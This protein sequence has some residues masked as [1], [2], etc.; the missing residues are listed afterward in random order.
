MEGGRHFR[1]EGVSLCNFYVRATFLLLKNFELLYHELC[2][3]IADVANAVLCSLATSIDIPSQVSMTQ[4][5]NDGLYQVEKEF[6]TN[7]IPI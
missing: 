3:K 7:Q 6:K 1:D 5:S 4:I 2:Y